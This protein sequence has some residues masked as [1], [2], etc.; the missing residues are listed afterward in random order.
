M[1]CHFCKQ[2]LEFAFN[3][4]PPSLNLTNPGENMQTQDSKEGFEA[5]DAYH[6]ASHHYLR[7]LPV[8]I[9]YLTNYVLQ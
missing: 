3:P 2:I 6:W 5:T 4:L 7:L 1:Y 8:M 9:P